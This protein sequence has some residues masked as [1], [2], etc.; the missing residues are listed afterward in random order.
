MTHQPKRTCS[1]VGVASSTSGFRC[2][3]LYDWGPLLRASE[4]VSHARVE[5]KGAFCLETQSSMS[6][7][8]QQLNF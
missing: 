3:V 7:S 2:R 4:V 8:L 5:L 1:K 6:V